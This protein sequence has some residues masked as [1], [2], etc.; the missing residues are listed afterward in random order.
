MSTARFDE[1]IFDQTIFDK[2]TVYI[3]LAVTA[4]GSASKSMCVIVDGGIKWF[5][6]LIVT[7]GSDTSVGS[8]LLAYRTISASIATSPSLARWKVAY[9]S[10]STVVATLT[11]PPRLTRIRTAYRSI[12]TSVRTSVTPP[13]LTK[14]KTAYRTL[15][16]AASFLRSIIPFPY[17]YTDYTDI[18]SF[19]GT[20]YQY[21]DDESE[22]LITSKSTTQKTKLFNGKRRIHQSVYSAMDIDVKLI[23]TSMASIQTDLYTKIGLKGTL[24]YNGMLYTNAYITTVSAANAVGDIWIVECHFTQDGS[25]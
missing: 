20:V 10:L 24:L 16:T 5:Y 12:T 21:E 14:I 11:T 13:I 22:H 9:L 1:A 18:V 3:T 8:I 4:V 15:S 23:F 19:C 25:L 6:S 2:L 7:S 17:K